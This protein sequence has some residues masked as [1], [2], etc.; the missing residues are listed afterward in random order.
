MVDSVWLLVVRRGRGRFCAAQIRFAGGK[1]H[2]DYLVWH[3]PA[4]NNGKMPRQE[5]AWWSRSLPPTLAPKRAGLD[6]RDPQHVAGLERLLL[7]VDLD[8]LA[9]ALGEPRG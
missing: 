6:L 9:A 4:F 2:R 5:G 3:Q 7:D 8:A 1:K